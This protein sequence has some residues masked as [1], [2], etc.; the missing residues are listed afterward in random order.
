M[1][2]LSG[3][4]SI[5]GVG[6]T[7]YLRGAGVTAR[8]MAVDAVRAA[9]NDAG[10][11]ARDVDGMMSYGVGDSVTSIAVGHD[12]GIDLQF[13]LDAVGGGSSIETLIGLATGAIEAGMCHTVAIFRSLNGYSGVRMGGSGARAAAPVA[14]V[15]LLRRTY[16]W[17]S[18]AQRFA[19]AFMRHMKDYG[20]TCEQVAHVK[21]FQSQHAASNPKAVYPE[22]VSIEDVVESRWI[23]T[24]LHLLDC[25]VETDA[26]VA[27]VVTSTERARDC[28]AM[29]VRVLGVA[30]RVSK[31][32]PDHDYG[33]GS[34]TSIAAERARVI[35][36]G[37][38]GV[39]PEDIDVTA[40]YDAFTWTALLQLE[41]YGFCKEGEGGEYVSSG[42]TRLGGRRP[43]NTS[44]GQLCEGY[45]NGANLVVENVRQL[46]WQADD[47]CPGAADDGEHTFDYAPGACRQVRN[48]ELA[49]NMGWATPALGS[50]LILGRG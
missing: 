13:N 5:V 17:S 18:P 3:K 43:N 36:F 33:Y 14:G 48:P 34:P 35:V 41:Q 30:G 12:L 49:M 10:L 47:R 46:R 8:R 28:R 20:T 7:P 40:A 29:P 21:A 19:P 25:C 39:D 44:G 50:A 45:T 27:L 22:V 24:P 23:T 6:E 16:G 26:A 38:A 4:C 37:M 42:D 32:R 15:D 9:I 1:G 31:P 2:S 11:C